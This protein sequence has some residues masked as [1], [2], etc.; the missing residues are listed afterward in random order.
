MHLHTGNVLIDNDGLTVKVSEVENF[1]NNIPIKNELYFNYV[2][3][4]FSTENGYNNSVLNEVFKSNQ[5][6]FEKIDIIAFGR[7]IYELAFGKELKSPYPDELEY[8]DLDGDIA[9]VLQLIFLKRQSK[10]SSSYN[11]TVPDVSAAELL[12]HKLFKQ[13]ESNG[14]G[15]SHNDA[16]N[17]LFKLDDFDI[18]DHLEHVNDESFCS[19]IK[20]AVFNQQKYLK[21]KL[22]NLKIKI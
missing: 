22:S 1:A 19:F 10:M 15:S 9:D 4:C 11:I 21:G 20:E 3:N 6:I 16:G 8:K 17:K 18:S 13:E 14:G 7:I 5:N 12:T 2:F